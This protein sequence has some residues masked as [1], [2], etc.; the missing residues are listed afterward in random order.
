MTWPSVPLGEIGQ[1]YGGGTPPKSR[2]E[3]WRD[4]DIPWLSP[5]DMGHDVLSST[6]DSITEAAVRESSVRLVPA[7]SVAVVVRSGILE[8]KLPVGLVPFET[9]LNQDMKA[10]VARP[11]IEPRWIAWGLR[12]FEG[13]LL[14]DTRK[15]GT[16]VASI[17]TARLLKFSLP[18]PA[19][20]E[21]R[22]IV[23]ILEDHL[24]RLDAGRSGLSLVTQRARRLWTSGLWAATHNLPGSRTVVLDEIAEVRLGRQR[25][26]KNHSGDRMGRYLR[27]ANVGWDTLRL[28]DILE[29]NF[30]EAEELT[31]RLQAGDIL[32]TEASGSP[33]EVGKSVLYTGHP[34]DVCFQ[35]TLLR[36]RAHGANPEFLQKYLLAEAHAG[37][38]MPEARGVGINHLGRA[39]LAAL[40]VELPTPEA[41]AASVSECRRLAS[42]VETLNAGVEVAQKRATNLRRAVLAAAFSGKLTG[43]HTDAEVIEEAAEHL[44]GATP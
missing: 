32:L 19:L 3:F 4:G 1:W 41:Q 37:R 13:H 39:K 6:I 17:E 10:V 18:V 11:G 20:A 29:M 35:N 36:V 22:R 16:T 44:E 38:F 42:R 5:K 43:H 15:A 28:D 21:Q 9:T 26:P 8:R 40:K 31:Y 24:S 27:A 7:N 23:E 2:P 12:A 14:R 33:R 25:S 30:T 34:K